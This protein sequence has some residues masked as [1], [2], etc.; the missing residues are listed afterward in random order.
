MDVLTEKY[1]IKNKDLIKYLVENKAE[2]KE[3]QFSLLGDSS[4]DFETFKFMIMSNAKVNQS[5]YKN[6]EKSALVL[7]FN[8]TQKINLEDVK[9]IVENKI[10]LNMLDND[11]HSPLHFYLSLN[12]ETNIEI[13]KYLIEQ[14]S[15]LSIRENVQIPRLKFFKEV[16]I[17]LLTLSEYQFVFRDYSFMRFDQIKNDYLNGVLWSI[18]RHK[19][20]D[21]ESKRIVTQMILSF[22]YFSKKASSTIPKP[23]FRMI[24]K[25]VM[26]KNDE[27]KEKISL[28][29]H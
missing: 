22:K 1:D 3:Q 19:Y 10:N 20:F 5:F 29:F 16:L 26:Y 23:I 4:F 7:Y 15:V 21:D 24:L 6:N 9:F 18:D 14:K 8:N 25:M 17:Y 2:I 12:D 27:I 11:K 13:V 28:F